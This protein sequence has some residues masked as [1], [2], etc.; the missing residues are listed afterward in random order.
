MQARALRPRTCSCSVWCR[1]AMRSLN[2]F[3][4][5]PMRSLAAWDSRSTAWWVAGGCGRQWQRGLANYACAG[6]TLPSPVPRH[7]APSPL[8]YTQPPTHLQLGRV[9]H[10]LLRRQLAIAH[11]SR[12][13]LQRRPRIA[14]LPLQPLASLG[15]ALGV[16]A[17]RCHL[18]GGGV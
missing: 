17:A 11:L 1:R 9:L 14:H 5:L 2:A 10:R 15:L 12:A 6:P 8:P 4:S 3:D 7:L 16:R 13:R 18:R